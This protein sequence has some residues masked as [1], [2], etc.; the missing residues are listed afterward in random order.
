[1]IPRYRS[2]VQSQTRP[3]I[4]HTI[5]TTVLVCIVLY[6][7]HICAT[8]SAADIS[9]LTATT[10]SSLPSICT[11]PQRG[12]CSFYDVCLE[13]RYHCGP[14]G[15]PLGLGQ[16]YCLAFA[17]NLAKFSPRGQVWVLDTMQCLERALVPEAEGAPQAVNITTCD[18]LEKYA[19]STHPAC[20][21]DNGLC[22]LPPSD[23]EELLKVIG[24]KTAFGSWGV[25]ETEAKTAKGCGELYLFLLKQGLTR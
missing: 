18:Q 13:S 10:S 1:M 12:N 9:A 16:K 6:L 23:W 11:N 22:T 19:L 24:I 7:S 5:R 2:S 21:I 4:D 14:S 8:C 25:V 20:Y 3:L 17:A 15:Y